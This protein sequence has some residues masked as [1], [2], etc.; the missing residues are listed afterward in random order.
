MVGI[1]SSTN[2]G[3]DSSGKVS[4]WNLAKASN[5]IKINTQSFSDNSFAA[6]VYGDGPHSLTHPACA[7]DVLARN[8]DFTA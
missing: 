1:Y 2:K 6:A 8:L 5:P 7:S 4:F 3:M